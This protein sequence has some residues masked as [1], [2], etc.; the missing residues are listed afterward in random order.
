LIAALVEEHPVE[1][2]YFADLH[3][4]SSETMPY[5]SLPGDDECS[6]KFARKFPLHLVTGFSRLVRGSI[7]R[8]L[9]EQGFNGFAC[10]GGQH[11]RASSVTNMSALLWLMLEET[12]CIKPG[13]CLADRRTTDEKYEALDRYVLGAPKMFEVTHRHSLD[14]DERF[15][16]EPGFT[17]F[18]KVTRDQLIAK[19]KNGPI[20]APFTGNLLMPLYQPSGKDGFFMV[21][22]GS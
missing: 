17:N 18:H 4:T 20:R 13:A 19:D 12:G 3:T 15:V 7:D 6:L 8:Y 9:H 11:E 5:L 22:E 10:E 21:E 1:E 16:M 14:G 2:R